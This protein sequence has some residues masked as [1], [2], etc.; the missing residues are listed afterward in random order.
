MALNLRHR[1]KSEL[2]SRLPTALPLKPVA[3]ELAFLR[4]SFKELISAY[5]TQVEADIAQLQIAITAESE[6][7]KKLPASRVADLRDMLMLLRNFDIKPPKGR[8]RDLKKVE[9]LV[10]DLRE[11]VD[12][13]E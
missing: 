5:S 6:S 7:K 1:V 8:R 4:K 2:T 9:S 3:E 13:W 11:I 10:G 12:R